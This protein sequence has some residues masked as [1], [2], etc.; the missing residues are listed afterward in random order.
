MVNVAIVEDDFESADSLKALL[1]RFA[2]EAN[3]SFNCEIFL[4]PLVFIT[5]FNP[6][7]D[8]IF[9][10]INMPS[11][12]G[13]KTSHKLREL[14]RDVVLVFVTNMAQYAIKGYDVGA[15]DFIVKP[16]KYGTL[17]LKM[18]KIMNMIK[19]SSREGVFI[20]T[21]TGKKFFLFN[22]ITYIEVRMHRI[23]YHTIKETIDVY[24]TLSQIENDF[25]G[26]GFS[27]CNNCYIVNLR[28]I[29]EV[30]G[31]M[32]IVSN[33]QLS[34]SRRKKKDFLRDLSDYMGG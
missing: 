12:D 10:D 25:K 3:E 11:C 29:S 34:I 5:K 31:D 13:I 14:D 26:R 16:V 27:R 20:S 9:M 8:L 32:V 7:Y 18:N 24:G 4:D 22:D 6:I 33:D 21:K 2:V 19:R 28:Y 17:S 30:K 1:L 15:S 23:I